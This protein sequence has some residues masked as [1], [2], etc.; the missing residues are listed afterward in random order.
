MIDRSI[1]NNAPE[2]VRASTYFLCRGWSASRTDGPAQCLR[3]A[4]LLGPIDE[5]VR[6]WWDELATHFR[7]ERSQK[8]LEIGRRGEQ[9]SGIVI[10]HGEGSKRTYERV[11]RIR[12]LLQCH[13]ATSE[14]NSGSQCLNNRLTPRAFRLF[15]TIPVN[16]V[17]VCDDATMRVVQRFPPK[18]RQLRI[19][20]SVANSDCRLTSINN[21]VPTRIRIHKVAL[22]S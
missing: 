16:Y 19:R 3:Y 21:L 15:A 10:H 8:L 11:K 4:G 5:S 22:P 1:D 17:A 7:A 9:L 20:R 14:I 12:R 13:S 6:Q 2:R 18:V